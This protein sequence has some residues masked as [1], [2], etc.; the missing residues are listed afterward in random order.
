MLCYNPVVKMTI[1]KFS[2][3]RPVLRGGVLL[4]SVKVGIMNYL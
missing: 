2:F 4:T 1:N 3:N